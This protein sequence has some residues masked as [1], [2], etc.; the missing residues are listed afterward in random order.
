M[1]LHRRDLCS[2]SEGCMNVC[3]WLEHAEVCFTAFLLFSTHCFTFI[4]WTGLAGN[5]VDSLKAWLQYDGI[6]QSVEQSFAW[7][8]VLFITVTAA[9]CSVCFRVHIKIQTGR[10]GLRMVFVC[11]WCY[12]IR[13]DINIKSVC[14]WKKTVLM[15]WAS[16]WKQLACAFL[17]TGIDSDSVKWLWFVC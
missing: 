8:A 12:T 16:K 3:R 7:D 5:A 2:H 4:L 17:A 14:S 11:A 6:M 9:S 15:F 1:F 10:S 13:L